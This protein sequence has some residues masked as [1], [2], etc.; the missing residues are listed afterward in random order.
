MDCLITPSY[1]EGAGKS[2]MEA[3]LN[4]LFIIASNVSGHKY[5]LNKTGNFLISRSSNNII[6]AIN[7]FQKLKINEIKKIQR[8]SFDRIKNKF[9]TEIVSK[10]LLKI[11]NS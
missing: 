8:K 1:T 4:G 2:V 3:M 6:M 11:L 10:N 5:L 7:K 9:S